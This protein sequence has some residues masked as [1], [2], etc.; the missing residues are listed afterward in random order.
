MVSSN[1]DVLVH[2]QQVKF[3]VQGSDSTNKCWY[4]QSEWGKLLGYYGIRQPFMQK[5][6]GVQER[7]RNNLKLGVGVREGPHRIEPIEWT[8][9]ENGFTKLCV[10]QQSALHSGEAE[11]SVAALSMRLSA[12]AFSIWFWS[13][14]GFL[15]SNWSSLQVERLKKLSCW[16]WRILVTLPT[17]GQ[18][19]QGSSGLYRKFLPLGESHF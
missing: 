6:Y 10:V 11:N 7:K 12:S 15:E 3:W 4:E 2:K 5:W 16:Q 9:Y 13:H 19:R 1:P 18:G 8:R 17:R 14:G